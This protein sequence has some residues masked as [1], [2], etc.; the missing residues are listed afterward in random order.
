M[1]KLAR[2][3][4]LVCGRPTGGSCDLG[5]G[6]GSFTQLLP[7]LWAAHPLPQA[8][9]LRPGSSALGA[10]HC[11]VLLADTGCPSSGTCPRPPRPQPS[12]ALW[13]V[14]TSHS[15]SFIPLKFFMLLIQN[16]RLTRFNNDRSLEPH[17]MCFLGSKQEPQ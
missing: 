11:Q 4:H 5:P 2:V 13:D 6:P 9:V 8:S 7:S 10:A 3:A 16:L 1:S 12:G 17:L 14:L 15:C